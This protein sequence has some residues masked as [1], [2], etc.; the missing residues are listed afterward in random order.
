M[1]NGEIGKGYP[2]LKRYIFERNLFYEITELLDT[3]EYRL[4]A[5]LNG[6]RDHDFSHLEAIKICHYLKISPDDYF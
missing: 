2:R 5:V 1:Q 4:N 3:D 6:M